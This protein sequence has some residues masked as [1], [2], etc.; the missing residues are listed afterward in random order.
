MSNFWKEVKQTFSNPKQELDET[1]KAILDIKNKKKTITQASKNEQDA[2]RG[3][4]ND[5]YRIIGET[6][7][8]LF[9]SGD[10]EIEKI[11]EMFQTV[12]GLYQTLDEKRA[13]M[14]EI[15]GRYDEE[16]KILQP[17]PPAG[18]AICP[19]CGNS[20]IPSEMLYCNKCGTKLPEKVTDTDKSNSDVIQQSRCP[21]CNTALVPGA[22]FCAACGHKL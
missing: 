14:N 5:E 19:N 18:Q 1:T 8:T 6:A 3:K 15:I 16:L 2:L 10:F 7:Y 22:V 17:A 20:Y 9:E 12:K 21:G 13:K 4:I 11:A